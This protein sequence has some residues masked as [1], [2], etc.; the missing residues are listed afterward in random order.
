MLNMA[1]TN[2]LTLSLN[3]PNETLP[4]V[5]QDQYVYWLTKTVP[6]AQLMFSL[7][8]EPDLWSSTHS[9]IHPAPT[10][11]T[12]LLSKDLAYAA[13]VKKVDPAAA[14]Q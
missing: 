13:A 6:G 9:E 10:T 11:Y 14:G 5:Y 8:N 3:V 12:E 1:I 7:D 4:D 2:G